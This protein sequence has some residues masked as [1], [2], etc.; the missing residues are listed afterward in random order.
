MSTIIK[1]KIK[2][3]NYYYY[4]E[5]KRVN[6]KPKLVNQKYLGNAKKLLSICNGTSLQ[7]SVLYSHVKDFGAVA[8]LYD[9]AKRFG[10][11]EMINKH[12]TKRKQGVSPGLYIL[13]EAINRVVS[14]TSTVNLQ[15]WYS[16]TCLPALTGLQAKLFSA[17]NFW[18]NTDITVE[19]ISA[20]EDDILKEMVSKYNIDITNIIYDATN[21]F[22]YIDTC[23]DCD[24]A[25]R[26]HSKEKR[27]DLKIV[28]LAMMVTPEFSIPL[29]HETY[30]GNRSDAKEF[31]IMMRKLRARITNITGKKVEITIIFD[32]GNNSEKNMNIVEDSQHPFHYVA[33]IKK[34]Q[35]KELRIIPKSEY[36]PLNQDRY[37]GQTAFRKTITLFKRQVEAIIV[38]NPTLLE[39]QLRGIRENM[40]KTKAKLLELQHKLMLRGSGEIV[41]GKKPTKESVKAA[42]SKILNI[43]YMDELFSYEIMECS[44]NILI[45]FTDSPHNLEQLCERELGKTALFTDR[46]ELSN[47]DIV[48]Y[49]RSA[50]HVES[51][52]RQ[53]KD[54]EHLAVR[55]IFHWRDQRIKIHIFT[56]VI[57]YRMCCLLRLELEK[58]GITTNINQ[59]IEAMSTMKHVT[60]FLGTPDKNKAIKSFTQCEGLAEQIEEVFKLKEKFAI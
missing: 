31:A 54:T 12:A 7:N 28:G 9:F 32:R 42:I 44:G 48:R 1:K 5:S 45:S 57:A 8:M 24:C 33:A 34:S 17:Q 43:E 23:N 56:C 25:K 53:M 18:N 46:E 11:V 60:T 16:K 27:N 10:L 37:P 36:I 15:S 30:P 29:L 20:M 13:I 14:P 58:Q 35:A 47:E 55:P 51:S 39:G 26:G 40:E 38:N 49:Y 21:F 19:S 50:W 6:G 59:M 4:V 3:I 2:G 22:T 52:F 41:K